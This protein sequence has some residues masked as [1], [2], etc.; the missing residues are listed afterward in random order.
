VARRHGSLVLFSSWE[1][2]MSLGEEV[3]EKAMFTL[4]AV[5]GLGRPPV[6]CLG[7]MMTW[8]F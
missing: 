7:L 5:E 1:E 8:V 3:Q 6:V 2:E 4:R